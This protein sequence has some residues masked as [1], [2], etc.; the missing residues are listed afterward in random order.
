[1]GGRGSKKRKLYSP[2]PLRT[3]EVT[4]TFLIV[5]DVDDAFDEFLKS[6]HL[7]CLS[8]HLSTSAT[9]DIIFSNHWKALQMQR[10]SRCMASISLFGCS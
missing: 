8:T 10:A 7:R 2:L 1:M 4:P 5:N 3:L 9:C 6:K